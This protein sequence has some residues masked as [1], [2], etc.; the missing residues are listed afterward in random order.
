MYMKCSDNNRSSTVYNLF[1]DAVRRYGLPSRVRSD[2]GGENC[3]F[4]SSAHAVI[5]WKSSSEYDHW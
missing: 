1:L 4:S 3:M 5:S 2:Q